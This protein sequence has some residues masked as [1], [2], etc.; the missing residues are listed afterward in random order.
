MEKEVPM[1]KLLRRFW[2][3]INTLPPVP[4]PKRNLEEERKK[5]WL[6]WLYDYG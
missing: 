3:W 5:R 1:K 6:K 2:K 4:P